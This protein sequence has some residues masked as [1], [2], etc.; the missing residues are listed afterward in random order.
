MKYY[1]CMSIS[2]RN[3][4][5]DPIVSSFGNNVEDPFAIIYEESLEPRDSNRPYPGRNLCG[6][7]DF[8]GSSLPWGRVGLEKNP[9]F[10]CIGCSCTVSMGLIEEYSWPSI[11]RKLTGAKVNNLSSPGS[12]MEFLCSVAFDS[13]AEFG[14]PKNVLALFPDIYR[15]WTINS[16]ADLRN[17]KNHTI[18][19]SW[20]TDVHEYFLDVRHSFASGSDK[21][22]TVKP[23]V[24]SDSSGRR[25][26]SSVDLTIF[27]S[28]TSLEMLLH[29]CKINN[30]N[31]K[32]SSWDNELNY[33]LSQIQHYENN[34]VQAKIFENNTQI[35]KSQ[36]LIKSSTKM[37]DTWWDG[38]AEISQI[39]RT[40]WRRLGFGDECNHLPQTKYQE[41]WWSVASDIGKHPGIHDQI[42]FAEHLLEEKI[43]NDFLRKMP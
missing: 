23:F 16:Y 41:K 28:F 18:H 35:L 39:Y 7:T 22:E 4:G 20:H 17:E 5:Q 25:A 19:A 33:L 21:P 37:N 8:D 2:R 34:Y 43:G 14:K 40:P 32:F 30:I 6:I 9:D 29:Y 11:I 13:F 36:N 1:P 27:N 10:V 24:F 26:T 42:H 38:E 12:G 3:S 15:M 31:F